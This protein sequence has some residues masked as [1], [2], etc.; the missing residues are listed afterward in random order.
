MRFRAGAPVREFEP[1]YRLPIVVGAV[2][3]T[4]VC[5]TAAPAAATLAEA[6]SLRDLVA[7]SEQVV[8]VSCTGEQAL[9]DDRDRI[10][11][12]YALRVEDPISG[13]SR[14]GDTLTLRSLGGELGDLAMRIEGEPRLVPG[15]RYVVFLRSIHGV[16][17]P[18]GMSQ[19]VLPVTEEHGSLTAHPG[20]AGLALVQQSGRG[21]LVPAPP[22]LIHPEPWEQLRERVVDIAQAAP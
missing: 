17:R 12:D 20:G 9:R 6:L 7:Q 13:A 16:M 18:V 22:A 11:T 3:A 8:L 19:G 14:A 21:Q 15:R 4:L 10:V 2:A 1:R 5:L